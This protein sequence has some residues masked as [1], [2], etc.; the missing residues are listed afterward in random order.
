M[1]HTAA[2]RNILKMKRRY[3]CIAEQT[4]HQ[5]SHHRWQPVSRQPQVTI[6]TEI[7]AFGSFLFELVTGASPVASEDGMKY[8][9]NVTDISLKAV[10]LG[11]WNNTYAS[12][13]EVRQMI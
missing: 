4:K 3:C 5:T 12:M 11:C 10:I 13:D 2:L 1:P 9:P 7:F 6:E 8:F